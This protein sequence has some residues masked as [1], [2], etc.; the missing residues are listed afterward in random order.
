[1]FLSIALGIYSL[2]DNNIPKDFRALLEF[3]HLDPEKKFWIDIARLLEAVTP[4]RLLWIGSGTVLYASISLVQSFGLM[5]RRKW[6]SWL[7]ISEGAF[8]IPIE[9]FELGHHYSVGL[10]VVL[11]LNIVIVFYLF[12]NRERLFDHSGAKPAS[13]R[14]TG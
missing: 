6:A 8:F 3:L 9:I 14:P 2:I 11:F 13:K 10:A 5:F 7:A 4:K 1:M 12:R